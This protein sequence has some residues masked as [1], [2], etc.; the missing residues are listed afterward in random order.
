M[1]TNASISLDRELV[2][3]FVEGNTVTAWNVVSVARRRRRRNSLII[4]V[5]K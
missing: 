2:R 5:F 1:K 4:G 3:V